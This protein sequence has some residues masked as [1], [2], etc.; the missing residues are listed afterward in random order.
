[1]SRRVQTCPADPLFVCPVRG[2]FDPGRLDRRRRTKSIYAGCHL[3]AGDD[4][5][6]GPSPA[7]GLPPDPLGGWLFRVAYT[8]ARGET[9]TRLYRQQGAAERFAK[10]VL[11]HGG[12]PR[13]HRTRLDGWHELPTCALCEVGF[14]GHDHDDHGA[15]R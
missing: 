5:K 1:M 3:S 9:F 2:V 6:G 8:T 15:A 7:R 11:D 13:L 14:I 4:V 10:K 12:D